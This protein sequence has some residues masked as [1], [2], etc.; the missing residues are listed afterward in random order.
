MLFMSFAIFQDPDFSRRFD[1][2]PV[3]TAVG[4]QAAGT[5]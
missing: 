1:F 2:F 3:D 5:Y 4:V